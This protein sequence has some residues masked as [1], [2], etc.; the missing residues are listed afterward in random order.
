VTVAVAEVAAISAEVAADGAVQE[1][2]NTTARVVVVLV[3]STH[4]AQHQS[5]NREVQ[6]EFY[7]MLRIH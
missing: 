7:K 1:A 6:T 2:V 3:T 5:R 4:H